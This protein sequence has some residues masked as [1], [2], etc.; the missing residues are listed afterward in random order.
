M[1]VGHH[2][3][4][5]QWVAPANGESIAVR[6]PSNGQEYTRIARGT[7]ADVDLAVRTA[8]TAF[9]R[10]WSRTSAVE[11]GRLLARMGRLIL[12]Q[13][14]QLAQI[15]SQDT[16][17]P[18]KQA[19]ADIVVCARYLEFYS[20]ACDK[21]HGDTIP[22]LE[23]HTV[24][25]IREPH[26]VTGHIIP[27]NYPAAMFG[28]SV[29]AALAAGNTC[30]VKPAEDACQSYLHLAELAAEAGL[31][32]G[33]LN[34]VT[35]YGH[36]AGS[37]LTAHPGISHISFTGSPVTGTHVAQ[38]ASTHHCPVT[39]ELGGKSPQIVFE[40]ADLEAAIPVICNAIVQNAG[41]TCSAGSRLLVQ[42][43]IYEQVIEKLSARFAQ[44]VV[45]PAEGNHD[46]GP[47]IN[48][49]QRDRVQ[50]FLAIAERDGIKI[51]AKAKLAANTPEGGYY[52]VPVLLRD[53]PHEHALA[54]EEVFGPVLVA[55]PFTDEADAIRLANDTAFGL[56]AGVWT[57]DGGR[58]LR[59]AR[60]FHGGQVFVNCYGAGGGI[61]LPFGGV[62]QSGYGREKGIEGLLSFTNVKTITLK[63]D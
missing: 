42:A 19:L 3:I 41:Q 12:A 35:G 23:G 29:A 59:L 58:Q 4:G 27:W 14:E 49:T 24:L 40:D 18:L 60:A 22:F 31:P 62:K 13:Q 51:A 17:K 11:R 20:G 21:L 63:H 25:T 47:L 30:V 61:E 6:N 7:A 37:A 16:G 26:G 54:Q 28:R 2:Y 5:N 10:V 56:I 38:S 53:V 1:V 15:E 55:M 45:G 44:V 46:C 34:I 9:D 32:S 48:A 43:S 50:S 36:E 8:R 52:Q 57:R 39:L 33:V